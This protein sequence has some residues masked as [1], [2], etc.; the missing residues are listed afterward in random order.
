MVCVNPFRDPPDCGLISH[1]NAKGPALQSGLPQAR[2]TASDPSYPA[3]PCDRAACRAPHAEALDAAR[4]VALVRAGE[5]AGSPARV[6]LA[7]AAVPVPC[8]LAV[9]A[10]S[11]AEV[12][13]VPKDWAVAAAPLAAV[14]FVP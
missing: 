14:E 2:S 1:P 9:A 8:S 13:F 7:P 6:L 12:G 10:A 3:C 5:R 4:W 11:L